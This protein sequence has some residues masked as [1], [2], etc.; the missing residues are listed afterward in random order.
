M[1]IDKLRVHAV[2]ADWSEPMPGQKHTA[3]R[4][5]F[6]RLCEEHPSAGTGLVTV[7]YSI[8][9]T[10]NLWPRIRRHLQERRRDS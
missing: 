7:R 2:L 8:R 4:R 5:V 3:D 6:G 9:P 1:M 10:F